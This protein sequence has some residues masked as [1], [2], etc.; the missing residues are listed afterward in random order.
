MVNSLESEHLENLIRQ[1]TKRYH[2]LK[3]KDPDNPALL[4]L[5]SEITFLRDTI[6]PI[7]LSETTVDYSEIRSFVTRSIRKL[8]QHPLAGKTTDIVFHVHLKDPDG[9]KACTALANSYE[10]D[11]LDIELYVNFEK[12]YLY[13]I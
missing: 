13:N 5:N 11:Y 10:K 3:R 8:E 12:S 1:K 2:E 6:L 9:D 7:V 4:Y